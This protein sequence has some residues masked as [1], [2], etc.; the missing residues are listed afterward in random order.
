LFLF[1]N[2][3]REKTTK[4]P[5]QPIFDRENTA[6][7]LPGTIGRGTLSHNAGNILPYLFLSV[8]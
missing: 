1:K 7:G 5:L 3:L 8:Q 2:I 6:F 4:R